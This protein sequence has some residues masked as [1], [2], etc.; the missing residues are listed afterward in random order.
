MNR[1]HFYSSQAEWRAEL[2]R[3]A[4]PSTM[5]LPY[6]GEGGCET[7]PRQVRAKLGIDRLDADTRAALLPGDNLGH[8]LQD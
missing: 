6:A 8:Y 4:R 5:P 3:L 2:L 7:M 1:V